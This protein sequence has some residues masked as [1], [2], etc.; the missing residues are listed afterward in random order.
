MA[1]R[2]ANAAIYCAL[3]TADLAQARALA[4]RLS[5]LVGGLKLGLEF[6][7]ANG[8]AGVAGIAGL[9]LPVFLDLKLHD[10]PN[11]VAGATRALTRLGPAIL[12]VHGAGGA[13]ML[14]AAA[15]AAKEEAAKTGTAR[16]KIVAVTVLTSISGADF[17][18]VGLH[19]KVSDQV[20]RLAALAQDCGL[21]GAVCSAAEAA[22]LRKSC[23]PD[24]L[25][26]VPGIRPE[27]A[28]AQDQKRVATPLE[29]MRMG[30]DI[31]VIGRPITAAK[32]PAE[33]AKRIAAE[34]VPA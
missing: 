16:P 10:I 27:W 3:D 7:A 9:G 26:V 34:L 11:T 6:F 14:K 13:A 22:T 20:A 1:L 31:L 2:T 15:E 19:G 23:R 24:F 5:G 4:G 32:D 28:Q 17:G 30:A 21:D 8:P 29:A 18:A 33:A 12:T 25:L